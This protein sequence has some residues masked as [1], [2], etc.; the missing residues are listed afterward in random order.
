MKWREK[1]PRGVMRER[2]TRV[3]THLLLMGKDLEFVSVG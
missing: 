1:P 2:D 3:M